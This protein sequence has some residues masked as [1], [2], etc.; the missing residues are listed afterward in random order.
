M[1][2]KHLPNK[3]QNISVRIPKK[4][5]AR[6]TIYIDESGT[7]SL[8]DSGT[9]FVLS[10]VIATNFIFDQVLYYY[11]NIKKKYLGYTGPIHAADLFSANYGKNKY[12]KQKLFR[13]PKYKKKYISELADF[14]DTIPFVFIT[15]VVNKKT[16]IN[17]ANKTH[18]KR[19]YETTLRKMKEIWCA[20]YPHR[21]VADFYKEQVGEVKNIIKNYQINNI[22]NYHPLNISYKFLLE[23]YNNEFIKKFRITSGGSLE[24]CFE[25]SSNQIRILEL[26]EKFCKETDE[27]GKLTKF[28]NN[29]KN[30]LYSISFPNKK[31]KFLG[32]EIADIISY[33]YFLAA[34]RRISKN[35]DFLPI[36]KIIKKKRFELN[37]T[38]NF[39]CFY[40]FK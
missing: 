37:T 6:N 12:G 5:S 35:S 14:L 31:S 24:V 2:K 10:G 3:T 19:P 30:N 25:S 26:T 13:F 15:C 17:S 8:K 22:N 4:T 23:K 1:R 29:L 33:G 27:N 40:K 21:S 39:E 38:K 32:L 11:L 7:A 18:I 36:W 16:L 34:E 9:F 28:S 20:E